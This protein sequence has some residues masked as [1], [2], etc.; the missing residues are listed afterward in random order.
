MWRVFLTLNGKSRTIFRYHI[1]LRSTWTTD[2]LI[3]VN[4]TLFSICVKFWVNPRAPYFQVWRDEGKTFDRIV[5]SVKATLKIDHQHPWY[6]C[7]SLLSDWQWIH[8]HHVA[9]HAGLNSQWPIIYELMR[10]AEHAERIF[11]P[12][13]STPG[14]TDPPIK[15]FTFI[16]LTFFAPLLHNYPCWKC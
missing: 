16:P 5:F 11:L 8:A 3:L 13:T 15:T 2:I 6:I 10:Q 9:K 4:G 14:K 7:F 12:A 1:T